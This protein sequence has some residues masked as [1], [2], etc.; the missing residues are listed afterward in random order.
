MLGFFLAT[1]VS[2]PKA[3]GSQTDFD[4]NITKISKFLQEGVYE[5]ILVAYNSKKSQNITSDAVILADVRQNAKLTL[6]SKSIAFVKAN[7]SQLAEIEVTG[8][9]ILY[10]DGDGPLSVTVNIKNNIIPVV[11][12]N[13]TL[14][15]TLTYF[16]QENNKHLVSL[17]YYISGESQYVTLSEKG[18][19]I[20]DS[21]GTTGWVS[22]YQAEMTEEQFESLEI[23]KY[24]MPKC[25]DF[26]FNI[27]VIT[28][29]L[30]CISCL[31]F[32]I[33]VI[34]FICVCC[35]SKQTNQDA[36][37]NDNEEAVVI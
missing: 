34:V 14:K 37:I 26:T 8:P 2:K 23:P 7:V 9:M 35:C 28:I 22:G 15:K 5:N 24:F 19:T 36:L 18:L 27:S 32:V 12:I 20:K 6:E 29:V 33:L 16:S 3:I 17:G 30:I 13:T 1:S 4:G 25:Y 11:I 31:I 21:N 10:I